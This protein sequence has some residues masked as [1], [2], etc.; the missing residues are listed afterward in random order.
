MLLRKAVCAE[1]CRSSTHEH[2]APWSNHTAKQPLS[3]VT[4]CTIFSLLK[5]LLTNLTSFVRGNILI[6]FPLFNIRS[7]KIVISIVVYLSMYNLPSVTS[8]CLAYVLIFPCFSLYISSYYLLTLP[9][10]LQLLLAASSE[11]SV[12]Q[13]CLLSAPV[14]GIKSADVHGTSLPTFESSLSMVVVLSAHLPTR[15]AVP[16]TP[17]SFRNRSSAV[18]GP[19]LWSVEQFTY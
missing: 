12:V 11:T 19:R 2:I 1:R 17:S 4:V 14:T 6:S 13:D 10:L 16:R 15:H 8:R 3:Q 18:A 7:L 9:L 5:P